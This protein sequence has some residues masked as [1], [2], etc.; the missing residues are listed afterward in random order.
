[1]PKERDG[2]AAFT[3]HNYDYSDTG[4]ATGYRS[5]ENWLGGAHVHVKPNDMD[6]GKIVRKRAE[7][8]DSNVPLTPVNGP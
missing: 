2:K 8:G 7:S 5:S 6:I 1:M 3:A 4:N